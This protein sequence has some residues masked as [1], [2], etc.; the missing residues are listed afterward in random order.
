LKKLIGKYAELRGW[1]AEW[2]TTLAIQKLEAFE[3]RR[4][5]KHKMRK[6]KA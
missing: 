3:R 1:D 6:K 5:L 4:E 2:A